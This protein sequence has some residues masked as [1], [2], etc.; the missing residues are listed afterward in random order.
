LTY[1]NGFKLNLKEI[2]KPHC[3]HGLSSGQAQ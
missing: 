3:S 2:R 1:L